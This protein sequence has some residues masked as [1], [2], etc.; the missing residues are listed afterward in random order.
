M[1]FLENPCCGRR[2]LRKQIVESLG[3]KNLGRESETFLGFRNIRET[4]T[5]IP[6]A[7][8]KGGLERNLARWVPR[9]AA[10]QT[11]SVG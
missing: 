6:D 10:K 4:M 2:R 8:F 11:V 7:V 5:H 9:P 3:K 1:R